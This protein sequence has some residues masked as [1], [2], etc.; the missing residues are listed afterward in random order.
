[1]DT[2]GAQKTILYVITKSNWGG[3]GRYVYDLAV[4]A[5]EQG[6]T[7]IVACGG[8]GFL[9]ERLAQAHIPTHTIHSLQR[10]ISLLA[11]V[12]SFGELLRL[13]RSERPDIV[14]LNS[15]KAGGLGALAARSAGVKKIVFTA[16]G[17]PFWEQRPLPVRAAMW[18][19]SWMTALLSHHVICISD[20]D[21]R[22]TRRMPG[23][24]RK[25]ARIYNGIASIDFLPKI[26]S[27]HIQVLTIGELN[28]NKNLFIGIDAI[29]AARARGAD[30]SYDIMGDGELRPVLREYIARKNAMGFISLL[31]FMPE[32]R[33]QYRKYDIFFLPSRKEG[34][35]YV[36]LEAGMA[37]LPVVASNVGG[38]P[39]IIKDDISGIL[40]SPDD[41]EGFAEALAQL[42]RDARRRSRLADVLK[43][44]V[45][46][47]FSLDHMVAETMAL[48]ETGC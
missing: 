14:H 34:V 43:K 13:F 46:R 1:M 41:T 28:R 21:L 6:Y 12:G 3:A 5:R 32:G 4:E 10:D 9:V 35:P 16:H 33:N 17:W 36:L 39:E 15:S 48:Y 8:E 25:V 26:Q 44:K 27:G 24:R 40:K 42:A 29:I 45:E 30:I 31:G 7:A 2:K 37:G 20:F 23:V 22:A 47:A 11:D 19:F 18:F 38:I